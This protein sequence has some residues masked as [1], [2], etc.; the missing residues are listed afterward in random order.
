MLLSCLWLLG[1]LLGLETSII[2]PSPPRPAAIQ[3]R[4][5]AGL[6]LRGGGGATRRPKRHPRGSRSSQP[7]ACLPAAPCGRRLRRFVPRRRCAQCKT[8][9]MPLSAASGCHGSEGAAGRLVVGPCGPRFERGW[10]APARFWRHS[11]SGCAWPTLGM[12]APRREGLGVVGPGP[13]ARARPAAVSWP[14]GS[15]GALRSAVRGLGWCGLRSMTPWVRFKRTR[16]APFQTNKSHGARANP[17]KSE[18]R[19]R[20]HLGRPL[21][22]FSADA[23]DPGAR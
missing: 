23:S 15:P 10:W 21:V 3:C 2:A 12:R 17:S 18:L 19:F 8:R 14:S 7:L 4:L 16:I 9:R 11:P 20:L 6:P 1:P 5:V 22:D 13:A